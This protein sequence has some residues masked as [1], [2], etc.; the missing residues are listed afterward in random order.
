MPGITCH[1]SH[2]LHRSHGSSGT[3]Y[4]V[5]L[6]TMVPVKLL[7]RI[8]G[9][10]ALALVC[11]RPG[12]R[13]LRAHFAA[14]RQSSVRRVG[15]LAT[16]VCRTG[17]RPRRL[18]PLRLADA[19]RLEPGVPRGH[20]RGR[21]HCGIRAWRAGRRDLAGDA[22]RASGTRRPRFLRTR[23][24]RHHQLD[25]P[26]FVE[27]FPHHRGW[28]IPRRLRH[29]LRRRLHVGPRDCRPRRPAAPFT[30]RGDRLLC[31]RAPRDATGFSRCSC[32]PP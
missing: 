22:C 32:K 11:R 12:D 25:G 30:H 3:D 15:K 5:R 16:S 28:R 13:P 2:G 21:V 26:V 19:R 9:D 20:H 1:G 29:G 4:T 10:V 18:L 24:P 23:T 27:R 31:R 8:A 17:A 14:G 7:R 6:R